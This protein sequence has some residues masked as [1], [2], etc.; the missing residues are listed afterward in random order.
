MF[1]ATKM[2]L[3]AVTASDS[4]E[5]VHSLNGSLLK[6]VMGTLDL[7]LRILAQIYWETCSLP[8]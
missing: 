3:V 6:L 4:K 8:P 2:I 5:L 1:V 7:P